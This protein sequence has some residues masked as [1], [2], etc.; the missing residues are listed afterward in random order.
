MYLSVR[1]RA[2]GLAQKQGYDAFPYGTLPGIYRGK[3]AEHLKQAWEAGFKKHQKEW[4]DD[5]R[6]GFY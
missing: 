6:D 4:S 2:M 5:Y 3:D 1:E